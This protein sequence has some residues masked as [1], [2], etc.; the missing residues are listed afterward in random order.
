LVLTT[1]CLRV[2]ERRSG[3][4]LALLSGEQRVLSR[5]PVDG[6]TVAA[7]DARRRVAARVRDAVA[8]SVPRQLVVDSS[9][10]MHRLGVVVVGRRRRRDVGKVRQR[11]GP[12]H[13]VCGATCLRTNTTIASTLNFSIIIIS[14]III[15][16]TFICS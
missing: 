12:S 16:I 8:A 11:R 15:I 6:A 4:F 14:I 13:V 7:R 9:T 2:R 5:S 10:A 1:D 3:S